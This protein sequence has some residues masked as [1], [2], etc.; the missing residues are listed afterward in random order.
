[1]AFASVAWLRSL[2]ARKRPIGES[3]TLEFSVGSKSPVRG[4]AEATT[5]TSCHT[6]SFASSLARRLPSVVDAYTVSTGAFVSVRSRRCTG[7]LPI[8]AG[9]SRR[10]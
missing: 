2:D 9:T 1:L 7:A 10:W 8:V 3:P 5:R 6:P 4:V